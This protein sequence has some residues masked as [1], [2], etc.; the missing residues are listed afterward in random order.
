MTSLSSQQL[1]EVFP[2][3]TVDLAEFI[4]EN[5]ESKIF[6]PGEVLM[7]PGQFFKYAMLI[8]CSAWPEAN[9]A[10]SWLFPLKKPK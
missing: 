1:M 10:L 9:P 5:G 6:K 4:H 8:A 3:F 7:K 2:I